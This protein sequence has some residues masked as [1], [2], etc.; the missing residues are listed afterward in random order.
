MTFMCI[1]IQRKFQ[2]YE[3]HPAS[4]S[5]NCP[6]PES[7]KRQTVSVW[8]VY[9]QPGIISFRSTEYQREYCDYQ[10]DLRIFEIKY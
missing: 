6:M 7:L 10:V 5:L 8:V 9:T 3:V 4:V 2:L 1:A